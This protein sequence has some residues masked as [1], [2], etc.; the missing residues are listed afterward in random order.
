MNIA[1]P[2]GKQRDRDSIA[3]RAP[4]LG[5]RY[6]RRNVALD[7]AS[8]AAPSTSLP[9]HLSGDRPVA[10]DQR[11]A[12]VPT[13]QCLIR[14]HQIDRDRLGNVR[15]PTGDP[16]YQRVSHHLTT[17][18]IVERRIGGA[19]ERRVDAHTLCHRQQRRHVCHGVRRRTYAHRSVGLGLGGPVNHR[20]DIQLARDLLGRRG[21]S[22]VALSVEV[23]DI[24]AHFGIQRP[25][26][27]DAEAGRLAHD[28]C[29][30]PF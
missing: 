1:K 2:L 7:R 22:S 25:A 14:H 6:S 12:V 11:R 4:D 19:L 28:Q 9:G 18:P 29:G 16:L 10:V 8:V 13:Q 30:A 21:D 23:A 17:G 15:R 26:V 27:R 5:W 20:L 24:G 3:T